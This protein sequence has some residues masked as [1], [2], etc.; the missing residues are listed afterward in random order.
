[1]FGLVLAAMTSRQLWVMLYA[2]RYWG[3]GLEEGKQDGCSGSVSWVCS[4][5]CRRD[6]LETYYLIQY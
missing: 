6:V 1:M 3:V 5:A 4:L 2:I